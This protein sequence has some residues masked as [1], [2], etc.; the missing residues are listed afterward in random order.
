MERKRR[1]TLV[2]VVVTVLIVGLAVAVLVPLLAAA[3]ERARRTRCASQLKCMGYGIHLYSS[4]FNEA[5]PSY[6]VAASTPKEAAVTDPAVA[7]PVA[8]LG[9]LYPDFSSDGKVF[10]CP[11]AANAIP[12]ER[13]LTAAELNRLRAGARE[14]DTLFTRK[15]T[16]YAYDPAHTAAHN[17]SVAVAADAGSPGRRSPNHGGKGQNVLYIGSNV[18]WQRSPYCGYERDDIYAPGYTD[19]W[20]ATSLSGSDNK[21]L[22]SYIRQ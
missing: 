13:D 17:A 4:D 22:H 16:D 2:G 6:G 14:F 10:T 18:E 5:F 12:V 3:R 8:S 21:T 11:S 15:H 20:G 19:P 9:M 7:N 1:R